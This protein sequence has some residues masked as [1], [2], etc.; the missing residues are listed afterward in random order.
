MSEPTLE[1]LAARV[2]ELERKLDSLP[3][4]RGS[5]ESV[6]RVAG[7]FDGSDTWQQVID[8][9]RAYRESLRR[10]AEE[11]A[12]REDERDRGQAG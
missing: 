5:L 8:E 10:E 12:D 3:P 11:E 7:L 6:L 2:A 4:E 1:S 9:G